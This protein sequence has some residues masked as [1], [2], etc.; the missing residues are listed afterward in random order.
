MPFTHQQIQQTCVDVF[1]Y[2]VRGRDF[3]T[4]DNIKGKKQ[5][6]RM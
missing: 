5:A 3:V 1:Y 4:N 2:T 6:G